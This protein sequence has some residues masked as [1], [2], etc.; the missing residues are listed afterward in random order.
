MRWFL[1]G[2]TGFLGGRLAGH[3]RE[4]G[5]DV[6]ALVRSRSRAARLE[7]SGCELVEGDLGGIDPVWL[8]GADVAVHA[9]AVYAVG[10]AEAEAAAMREA[11]VGGTERVLDAAATAGVPRV[12]YVSTQNVL[13]DTHG[14]VVDETYTR[15]LA[16]GFLSVYDETKYR[17]HELVA[18]RAAAGAPIVTVMPGGIYGPGDTSQ[19][20]AQIRDAMRGK[21]R[22]VSFPTLGINAVYVDDVVAGIVLA[23]D[24]GSPGREYILGGERT[25]M[26]A[27]IAAAAAAGGHTPPRLT[28]PTWAIRG[29]APL[30]GVIGPALG[31]PRNLAETIRAT[32]AVTY[33]GDDARARAELGYAPRA[34]ADGMA[35]LAVAEA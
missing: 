22:Y 29:L 30:S 6:V 21:L 28:I 31:L 17:S 9:A 2:A 20:G 14:A 19:L 5:D 32:D 25:T 26:T 8:E 23:A 24:R 33:W 12:A 7:A 13:G 1:T 3:L 15:D 35:A 34:L 16:V 27:L 18:E 11:N 10:V 4:R